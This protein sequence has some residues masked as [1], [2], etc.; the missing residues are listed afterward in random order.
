MGGAADATAGTW[1]LLLMGTQGYDEGCSMLIARNLL[2]LLLM[3][4][5]GHNAGCGDDNTFYSTLDRI[6][7]GESSHQGYGGNLMTFIGI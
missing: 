7:S 5:Q 4:T 2:G 3:G 6:D 1:G